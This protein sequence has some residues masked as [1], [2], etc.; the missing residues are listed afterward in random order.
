[1]SALLTRRQTL[2]GAG[3]TVAL[4]QTIARAQLWAWW[5]EVGAGLA[6]AWLYDTIKNWGLVSTGSPAPDVAEAHA[7]ASNT[8]REAGYEVQPVF[9]GAY[10]TGT[11]AIS[12]ATRGDEYVTLDTN[13][14]F[15]DARRVCTH[16]FDKLATANNNRTAA[17]LREI[18]FSPEQA[19][20]LAMPM[21]PPG[22]YFRQNGV[23]HSAEYMTP[24]RGTIRWATVPDAGPNIK[25]EIRSD[26]FNRDILHAQLDSENWTYQIKRV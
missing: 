22:G 7:S 26:G 25:T 3:A 9:G 21:H 11:V 24:G 2:I 4:P 13:S 17:V 14:H 20:E 5:M 23:L 16:Q 18:G 12:T 15:V 10:S 1:M 8:L 6:S 19:Q